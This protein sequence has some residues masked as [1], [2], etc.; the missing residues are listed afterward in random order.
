MTRRKNLKT[1]AAVALGGATPAAA[2][3]TPIQLHVDL[4]VDPAKEKTLVQ[5]FKTTFRP[6]MSKQPG[7]VDVKLMKLRSAPAGKAPVK[8]NHR[9]I[10]SFE[11]EEQRIAWTKTDI[12]QVVWPQMQKN[13]R[14][15][16]FNAV[17]FDLI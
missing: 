4:D 5:T 8:V 11:T 15:Q 17:L 6:A 9:L 13:F 10:I 1:I 7:F 14:S 12:H 16:N 3:V 2:A